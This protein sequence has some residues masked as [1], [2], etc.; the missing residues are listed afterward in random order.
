MA[1]EELGLFGEKKHPD[2]KTAW[3]FYERGQQFNNQINLY[4]TVKSNENFYVGK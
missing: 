4:E 1:D 3:T 2:P